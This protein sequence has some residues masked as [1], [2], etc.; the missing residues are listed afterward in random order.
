M[1]GSV[2]GMK[3]HDGVPIEGAIKIHPDICYTIDNSDPDMDDLHRIWIWHWCTR[4]KWHER[5][6]QVNYEGWSREAMQP[7]W[8]A[9]GVGAH[10]LISMDP[11]HLEPSLLWSDCCGMHGFLRAGT[12]ESV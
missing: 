1:S 7:S 4:S 3:N 12:W 8:R 9:A 11:L 10:D 5:A 2:V 6:Q